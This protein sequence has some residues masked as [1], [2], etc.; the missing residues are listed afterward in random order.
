M[1]FI[2]ARIA[3]FGWK[4][5]AGHFAEHF[6]ARFLTWGRNFFHF[7]TAFALFFCDAQI[8]A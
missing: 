6:E 8:I 1:K 2:L 4:T 3:S 5:C 7:V